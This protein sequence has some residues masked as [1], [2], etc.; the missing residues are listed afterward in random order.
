MLS[1][2]EIKYYDRQLK[3]K[4]VGLSGQE[5]LKCAN[6]LIIGAGGLGCP[7]L[8]YLAASGVGN[9][10]IADYDIVSIS[11]IHRQILYTMVDVGL[12]KAHQATEKIKKINPWL[13]VKYFNEKITKENIFLI[14]SEY[15]IIVDACDS[16]A[17]RYLIADACEICG[18]TVVSGAINDF[19]GQVAVFGKETNDYFSYRDFF[20]YN[21]KILNTVNCNENGVMPTLPG[22]IGLYQ[23][24]EVIKL[25]L[26]IGTP[27]I[28]KVKLINVLDNSERVLKLKKSN[29]TR[30][31]SIAEFN[32]WAYPVEVCSTKLIISINAQTF[33]KEINGDK[34]IIDV[35]E[36][37]EVPVIEGNNINQISSVQVNEIEQKCNEYNNIIFICQSGKRS[38]NIAQKIKNKFPEKNIYNLDQG[39]NSLNYEYR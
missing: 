2:E 19:E 20:S 8:Q 23:A 33:G 6:V 10:G 29:D 15:D 22:L 36:T 26:G 13:K 5:K 7:I 39:V 14:I 35:R 25:I 27:L 30:P 32:N 3:L 18:K 24:N 12:Y 31:S 11:N 16:I 1:N 9:L 37:Y 34:L 28:G 38:L 4:S 17:L 21:E